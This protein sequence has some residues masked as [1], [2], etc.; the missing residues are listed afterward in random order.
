MLTLRLPS[1]SQPRVAGP[2]RARVP[3][4]SPN[5]PETPWLL[6]AR[7]RTRIPAQWGEQ[8]GSDILLRWIEPARAAGTPRVVRL[9]DGP[10]APGGVAISE[11]GEC[12]PEI[13]VNGELFTVYH[14]GKEHARPFFFPVLGPGGRSVTRHYPME[15]KTGEDRDHRHHR[16]LWV[17]HGDVNGTDN[18][19]EDRDHGRIRHQRFE[20]GE[21]GP[22]AGYFR[23]RLLWTDHGGAPL[24]EETRETRV[25]A[26]P[27]DTR[28]L[29]LSLTFLALHGPVALGATKEG[30]LASVRVAT[31][32]DGSK[33]GRIENGSGGVTEAQCW[34]KPSPWCDYSGPVD[35][36]TVGIAI[37]DH[38][39]NPLFPTLWHARDY[40]LMTANPLIREPYSI[41]DGGAWTQR[42]RIVVHAGDA[43]QGEIA[44]HYRNFAEPLEAQVEA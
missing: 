9:E 28:L 11:V 20:A 38:P 18:W 22:V 35:G 26:L 15:E 36:A 25:W 3:L 30:G 12:D 5:R 43:H 34:G 24:M 8:T 19:S 39:E 40:G 23:E 16:S 21:T 41:P 33:G 10:P 32:M 1:D 2:A 31:S 13:K 44:G 42:Y 14:C 37:L 7:S 27:G 17:A 6:D 29:D 4:D